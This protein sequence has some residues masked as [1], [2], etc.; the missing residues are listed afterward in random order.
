MINAEKL[1]NHHLTTERKKWLRHGK[2][3]IRENQVVMDILSYVEIE[4]K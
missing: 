1:M 3:Y 2:K 4:R